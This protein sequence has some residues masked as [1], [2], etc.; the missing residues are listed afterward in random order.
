M[1][2]LIYNAFQG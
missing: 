1:E 2:L